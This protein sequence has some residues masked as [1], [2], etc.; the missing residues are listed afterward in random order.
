MLVCDDSDTMFW[1]D[2]ESSDAEP[3][4]TDEDDLEDGV[5]LDLHC[6]KEFILALQSSWSDIL[7]LNC[8]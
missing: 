3:D 2:S 5:C 6:L 7:I 4:S 1:A 8:I